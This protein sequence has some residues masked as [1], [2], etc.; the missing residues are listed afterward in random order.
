MTPSA[1]G[2]LTL[3]SAQRQEMY[4]NWSLLLGLLSLAAADT[5][6]ATW[7]NDYEAARMVARQS[8]KPLLVVFR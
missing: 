5:K 3:D 8:G 1:F 4:M 2:K 6:E 7:L